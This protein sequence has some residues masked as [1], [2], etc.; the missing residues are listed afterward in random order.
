MV[1]I[2][3]AEDPDTQATRNNLVHCHQAAARQSNGQ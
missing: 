2:L 1:R 3:G